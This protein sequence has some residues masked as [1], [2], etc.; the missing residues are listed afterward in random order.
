M[1]NSGDLPLMWKLEGTS[2]RP[3]YDIRNSSGA[4]DKQLGGSWD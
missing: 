1:G 3:R 4:Y 2:N